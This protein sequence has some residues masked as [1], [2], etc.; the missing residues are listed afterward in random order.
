MR[1]NIRNHFGYALRWLP[2]ELFIRCRYFYQFGKRLNL[3][4][5]I[6]FNEKIQWLKLNDRNPQYCTLVDKCKAKEYA[7]SIIGIKY[8]IPT[9]G[10]WEKFSDI[11]FNEL[12][13]NFVL[14]CSHDSGGIVICKDKNSFDLK[15]AEKILT[16]SLNF[17]Y[18]YI[19]REWP[20]KNV[21]PR[22]IAEEYKADSV[23]GDLRDYKFLCFNGIPKIMYIATDRYSNSET[24]FDFFEMDG[25][26]IDVINGHPNAKII[27]ELPKRFD[28]MQ[29]LAAKLS[30]GLNEVRID[31]YEADG[32]VFFGEFTLYHMSGFSRFYPEKWDYKLGEWLQIQR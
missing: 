3:N 26:H 23:Y 21:V 10:V 13:N 14:K 31:F 15:S 6:T 17:N 27:P 9:L 2:D 29:Q 4:P 8:I 22:I 12:P 32:E 30:K 7:A 1:K 5:P 18:Y 20:Y 24:C 28:L 25:K 19:G 16:D 11:P